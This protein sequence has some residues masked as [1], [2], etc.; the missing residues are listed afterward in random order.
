M[1]DTIFYS[2]KLKRGRSPLEVFDKMRKKI[3]KVG[4]T[5]DWVCK[6]DEDKRSLCINFPDGRSESFVLTF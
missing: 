6:I 1:A 4:P 2:G 5:K 3:K